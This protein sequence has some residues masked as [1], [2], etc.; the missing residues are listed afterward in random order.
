MPERVRTAGATAADWNECEQD[1]NTSKPANEHDGVRYLLCQSPSTAVLEKRSPDSACGAWLTPATNA[2]LGRPSGVE[3]RATALRTLASAG[4]GWR[5]MKTTDENEVAGAFRGAMGSSKD[6]EAQ[7]TKAAVA[8]SLGL[9][10]AAPTVG[11]FSLLRMVGAGA[12]GK[13]FAAYDDKLDRKVAVKLLT[14]TDEDSAARVVREAKALA[15]LSHPHVVQ[16]YESGEHQGNPFIAMEFL[17]GADLRTWQAGARAEDVLKAYR[18]A[19]KGLHAAHV[20][21]LVHRDFK[22]ENAVVEREGED[23]VRVRVIDFGLARAHAAELLEATDEQVD[24]RASLTRNG[25]LVGTPVYMA[26]EQLR[27]EPATVASDQFAFC[28]ALSEALWGA[29]PFDGD[30]VAALVDAQARGPAL[31]GGPSGMAWVRPVLRRGLSLQPEHRYPSMKALGD[32]LQRHPKRRQAFAAVGLVGVVGVGA[33][34][35]D[36]T[37]GPCSG[38]EDAFSASWSDARRRETGANFVGSGSSIAPSTWARIEPQLNRFSQTWIDQHRD[39]CEAANVR[40]EQSFEVMDRR[41]LCLE[42]SRRAFE[43]AVTVL[44]SPTE[45]VVDHADDV[46]AELPDVERCED[47]D[48]LPEGLTPPPAGTAETIEASGALVAQS[49]ALLAAGDAEGAKRAAL[50][51]RELIEGLA[52]PPAEVAAMKAVGLVEN[53]LGNRTEALALLTEAHAVALRAGQRDDAQALLGARFTMLV[54][55]SEFA[56]ADALWPILSGV[57]EGTPAHFDALVRGAELHER[58]GDAKTAV[59]QYRLAQSRLPSSAS[60]RQRVQVHGGLADALAALGRFEDAEI[61]IRQAIEE[62]ARSFGFEHPRL[63]E[64]RSKLADILRQ[65]G[66]LPDALEEAEAA[67]AVH[68]TVRAPDH[69]DIASSRR[70]VGALQWSI[71]SFEAAE[72]TLRLAARESEA[73]FGRN[74]IK[75]AAVYNNLAGPL[76]NLGRREEALEA[77]RTALEIKEAAVG[78]SHP[79][80]ARTRDNVASMLRQAGL[81]QEAERE[82]RRALAD[83][84]AAYGENHHEVAQSYSNLGALFQFRDDP[85]EAEVLYG[86]AVEIAVATSGEQHPDVAHYRV[87]RANMLLELDRPDEAIPLLRA[88]LA[89]RES[90]LVPGSPYILDTMNALGRALCSAGSLEEGVDVLQRSVTLGVDAPGDQSVRYEPLFFLARCFEARGDRGRADAEATRAVELA[91]QSLPASESFI[92]AVRT[93]QGERR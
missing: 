30:S 1:S 59:E 84:I 89:V 68:V 33:V 53:N 20:A 8:G 78:A 35:V 39:A 75:T 7:A 45:A 71:G 18:Q 23:G 38:S 11:R 15:R 64:A 2:E 55:A 77:L 24:V 27:G 26:P 87:N 31:K 46:V 40:Q 41:M 69:P 81:F 42:R 5:V 22:P 66:R 4:H 57:P 17:D 34:A 25:Q 51:S 93:W 48:A 73:A 63:A 58:R 9:E 79:S 6:A 47:V 12:M 50:R 60:P 74:H 90:V 54:D 72:K 13:V 70:V 44:D 62:L 36:R 29:R 28:V 16:I 56:A 80:T 52:Y 19:A 76:T 43:A 61:E 49:D 82:H 85:G 91:T 86:K 88:A 67:L 21:D 83:R 92:G 37:G 3:H 10:R 65:A 14:R 32:A